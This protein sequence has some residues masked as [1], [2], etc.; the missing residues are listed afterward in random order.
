VL[1]G[2][3]YGGANGK[4]IIYSDSFPAWTKDPRLE[5]QH[6]SLE[7]LWYQNNVHKLRLPSLDVMKD[8]GYNYAWF[9][10]TPVID[11]P[12]ALTQMMS[13]IQNHPLIDDINTETGIYYSSVNDMVQDAMELNCDAVANCTGL[14]SK[15]LREEKEKELIGGRGVTVHYNRSSMRIESGLTYEN[16]VAV[17]TEEEPWGTVTDPAYIIPRGKVLLVG[18]T[19]HM[20]DEEPYPRE[21]ELTRM[22]RNAAHLGLIDTEKEDPINSWVGFRPCRPTICLKIEN[23]DYSTYKNSFGRKR[24]PVCHN[25]GHGGSGWT[26]FIGAAREAARLLSSYEN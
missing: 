7:M 25:Y 26:V 4:E 21:K 20:G 15:S 22:R 11:P 3:N 16:D 10:K 6:L 14:G 18:G 9:L 1:S 12:L 13:Y 19:C 23:I 24:F 5:F 17:T 2:K 8:A